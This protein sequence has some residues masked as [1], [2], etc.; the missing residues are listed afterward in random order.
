MNEV[1]S[2]VARHAPSFGN[3][4]RVFAYSQTYSNYKTMEVITSQLARNLLLVLLCVFAATL[5]LIADVATSLLVVASVL[6]ALVDVSGFMH[7]WGLSVDTSAAV[8]LTLAVGLAVDYSAHVA[9]AF[10]VAGGG[11]ADRDARAVEALAD[12]GPAVLNGGCSTFLAFAMLVTSRSYVFKT[13]FKI[14]LLIVV[15]GL[16]HGLV[17]LPV[18]L[19]ILGPKG[20]EEEEEKGDGGNEGQGKSKVSPWQEKKITT[21]SGNEDERMS[22][23]SNLSQVET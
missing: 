8:L 15:F 14:F 7:L 4:S 3:R 17:L 6:L 19:S 9:H 1:E 13:F 22:A 16:Y 5:F 21:I 11:G 20:E 10:M 18:L 23:G 2:I 12:M